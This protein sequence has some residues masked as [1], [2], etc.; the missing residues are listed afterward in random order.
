MANTRTITLTDEQCDEI[1]DV[2]SEE[3][4]QAARSVRELLHGR[5]EQDLDED[6]GEEL[7]DAQERVALWTGIL[8]SLEAP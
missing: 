2:G 7:A 8:G 3:L 5:T 6:E 1:I 4:K